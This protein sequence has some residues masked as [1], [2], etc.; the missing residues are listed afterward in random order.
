MTSKPD[1]ILIKFPFKKITKCEGVIDYKIIHKI[2]RKIQANASTIQSE[3]IGGQHGILRLSM[4]PAIYHTLIGGKFQRLFCPPQA[5]P[6]L[7]NT[8]AAEIPR[9]IQFHA[10]QVDQWRQMLNPEATTFSITGGEV[11]KGAMPGLHKLFQPHT[12]GTHTVPL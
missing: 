12:C 8:D 9:Y 3:L 11:I 10:A 6:V 1:D 2:H 7:I 5:A 4:Q